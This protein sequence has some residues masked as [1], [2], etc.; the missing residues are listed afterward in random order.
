MRA[1]YS[2]AVLAVA[3]L[4]SAAAADYRV[5]FRKG[6]EAADLQR[7]DEA[8]DSFRAAIAQN[9][10]ESE[11][12]VFLSGVFSTPYL[13]HYQL[14]RSLFMASRDNCSEALAEW[15]LSESQGAI[16]DFARLYEDLAELIVVDLCI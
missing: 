5:E 2:A 1:K 10:V 15:A 14:G 9:P 13:P 4:S 8:A 7:W 16:R 12:R 11:E 3:L 6:M